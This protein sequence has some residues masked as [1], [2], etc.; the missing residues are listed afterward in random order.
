MDNSPQLPEFELLCVILNYGLGSKVMKLAKQ[1]GVTGGTI[2][3]GRGTVKNK[4]LELLDL[5]EV[6]K[7]IVIMISTKD[8]IYKA[9]EA[10]KKEL[11]LIKKGHGIVFTTSVI[12]LFGASCYKDSHNLESR[13]AEN[14][15]YKVIYVIVDRGRAASVIEAANKAGSSGGTIINA[16]GSGIHETNKIFAMDIEPEK[17]LVLLLCEEPLT[18]SIVSAIRERAQIDK[19]GNGIIFVQNANSAYGLYSSK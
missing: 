14:T 2:F 16:R 8:I 10:M 11:K 19:P 13:G 1:H 5:T 15:M 17:E 3:L 9:M 6:R 12:N 4:I 18:D 7:E